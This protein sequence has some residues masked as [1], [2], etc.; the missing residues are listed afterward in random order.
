MKNLENMARFAR[1][2]IVLTA[3]A[4]VAVGVMADGGESGGNLNIN[5]LGC[6]GWVNGSWVQLPAYTCPSSI[7][8]PASCACIRIYDASGN[9][10]GIQNACS[11]SGSG[12]V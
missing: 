6:N 10:I 12:N 11:Y 5:C 9:C 8:N 7:F 3:L 1:R 2:A 4:S